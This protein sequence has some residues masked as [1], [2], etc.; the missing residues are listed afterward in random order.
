MTTRLTK[1]CLFVSAL[2]FSLTSISHAAEKSQAELD[3]QK[4]VGKKS[5]KNPAYAYVKDDPTF[6]RVL[7]IGDSISIGYTPYVRTQLL[8]LIHISEPTRPY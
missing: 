8:S 2:L 3:W 5:I 6:P 1:I 4:S 7:I